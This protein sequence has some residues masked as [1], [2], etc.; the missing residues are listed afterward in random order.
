MKHIFVPVHSYRPLLAAPITWTLILLLYIVVPM[1]LMTRSIL[2]TS[3]S[4]PSVFYKLKKPLCLNA[5]MTL[6]TRCNRCYTVFGSFFSYFARQDGR[7]GMDRI[8]WIRLPPRP[9]AVP[10]A[11]WCMD[12]H[13]HTIH[14]VWD[15]RPMIRSFFLPFN[16]F[17]A[18]TTARGE[19]RDCYLAGTT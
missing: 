16:R 18:G 13:L 4:L 12:H 9:V 7:D 11:T 14:M 2:Q 3:S 19:S 5:A 6:W 8:T 10:P 1:Y 17:W 15:V